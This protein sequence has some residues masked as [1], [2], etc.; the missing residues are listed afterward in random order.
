MHSRLGLVTSKFKISGGR[1]NSGGFFFNLDADELKLDKKVI[2]NILLIGEM[3]DEEFTAKLKIND[4]FINASSDKAYSWAEEQHKNQ[5]NL[6]LDKLNLHHLDF[7][8]LL[9][10]FSCHI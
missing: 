8:L 10:I 7:Q 9:V 4:K 3:K 5:V 2:N 6:N 1:G